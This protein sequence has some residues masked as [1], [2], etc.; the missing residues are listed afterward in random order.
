MELMAG[1]R[2]VVVVNVYIRSLK[3]R[4]VLYTD[5]FLSAG[6][7]RVA[8]NDAPLK[9]SQCRGGA[10]RGAGVGIVEGINDP[11]EFLIHRV[12]WICKFRRADIAR[13]RTIQRTL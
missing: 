9:R 12:T 2:S 11:R 6:F 13:Y 8:T 7:I 4:R 1:P 3:L 10:M 5:G